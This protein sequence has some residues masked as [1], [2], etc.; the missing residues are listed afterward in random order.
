MD[1]KNV[2][3]EIAVIG[4]SIRFPG[5]NNVEKFWENIR[6]GLES[7]SRFSYDELRDSG[8]DIDLLNRP[9]YVMA[10]AII[11]NIAYIDADFFAI[12]PRESQIMDPQHRV[13]LECAW[14][15]LEGAGYT[16]PN[17]RQRVG[18]YGGVSTNSYLGN[19]YSNKR[20][21]EFVDGFQIALGNDKDFLSTRVSYKL[22]LTGPSIA[23]QTACST[24]LVA[25]HLAC[26]S[27]LNYECDMAL[28]GG[29]SIS[30]PQKSGYLYHEGGITSPD[31]HCRAF[32]AKAQGTV[33]GS[34]VGVVVLKRLKEAVADGDNIYAIVKG[35]AINNDGAMKVGYTAPSVQGQAAVIAEAL[36]VASVSPE[37]IS[38]VEAHGT[39]TPLGD[40]IE[41]AALTQAFRS[42]TERRG[43]CAIGSVKTNIGHLDAAAGIAGFI[44]TVLALHHKAL[45][46]SLHFEQ[47]N[48]QIDFG[49]SPFYV[50]TALTTWTSE[51]GPRRAGVSSF[52]IG[53]TN[54]HVILEEAP[55]LE[56]P[57]QAKQ[58]QLLLFS[59]RTG[60][61][62]EAMTANLARHF[63]EHPDL[64]LADVAYT[65]HVGRKPFT[66]RRMLVCQSLG[67]AAVALET[68]DPQ[69]I[70]TADEEPRTRAVAFMFPGQG[71]QYVQMAAD[72]YKEEPVFRQQ[73]DRCAISLL[74]PLGLDLRTVL[75]PGE[76]E[77]EQAT[78]QLSQTVLAQPALFVIEY[79]LA[80]LW[81]A[82]GVQPQAMIGH[83]IGE[84]VA[85]CLAG[86]ISLDDALAV[87]A[88]RGRLMQQLPGGAMLAVPLPENEVDSILG[89]RLSLAAVNGPSL[90]IVAGPLN[91]VEDLEQRLAQTGVS[92]Q[93]LHTSHA[94]HSAMMEP[95]MATFV[96]Q[97]EGIQLQA[98]QIPYISNVTGTWITVAE[99]TDPRYWARHLRH[100][101]RFAQGLQELLQQ[102]EQILLEV[103]PGRTLNKLAKQQLRDARA[104]IVLS[105][106]RYPHESY[107]DESFLLHTLGQLWLSGVQPDWSSFY[108]IQHRHRIPLPTYPFERKSFWVVPS[109][110]IGRDDSI[111]PAL[112]KKECSD[113]IYIHSWRRTGAPEVLPQLPLQEVE[114]SWLIFAD[115]CG[116]GAELVRQMEQKGHHVISV[117]Q[118]ERFYKIDDRQYVINPSLRNDY[119]LLFNDLYAPGRIITRIVH[120]WSVSLQRDDLPE[121]TFDQ[122]QILGYLSVISIAQAIAEIEMTTSVY[123]FVISS[124]VQE[125]TGAEY[126]SPAKA[127]V[128]GPCLVI[129]QESNYIHCRSIDIDQNSLEKSLFS[130][131]RTVIQE[132]LCDTEDMLVSFRNGHRWIHDLFK[133]PLCDKS[134]PRDLIKQDGV[135]MITGGVGDMSSVLSRNISIIQ[136]TKI[137][138]I[139]R[140]KMPERHDWDEW[141][142][143]HQE[144]D[145][146]SNKI[147]I[148]QK[149]DKSGVEYYVY[150]ADVSNESR[151]IE[152]IDCIYKR[153]GRINGLI[154]AAGIVGLG[155]IVPVKELDYDESI[156]QF[157]AKIFGT[158]VLE[159]CFSNRPL[160]FCILMSSLS[161]ILG[162]VGFTAY[163]SANIY[164]SRLAQRHNKLA[165][166][167]WTVIDWDGWRFENPWHR[168]AT[169]V[170]NA[171]TS[172]I[173]ERDACEIFQRV[174]AQPAMTHVAVSAS[175][176]QYGSNRPV[177]PRTAVVSSASQ[178]GDRQELH[179]RPNIS[180]PYVAPRNKLEQSMA[181]MWQDLL[182][183][184]KIGIEDDFFEVGG[185]SLLAIQLSTRLRSALHVELPLQSLLETP[186]I[187]KLAK[188]MRPVNP[189]QPT[190]PLAGPLV[191]I[192]PGGSEVPLFCVHPIGGSVLCYAD[193]ARELGSNQP[194]YGLQAP[195]LEAMDMYNLTL[196][197]MAA[198]YI[199]AVRAVWPTGPYHLVGLSFGG[200]VA[201]EMAQQLQRQG[202]RVGILVLLDTVT[203]AAVGRI[204]DIDDSALLAGHAREHALRFG[205]HLPVTADDLRRLPLADQLQVVL[206]H[207][208][209][210]N[211]L[212]SDT[213]TE[214]ISHFLQGYKVRIQAVQRYNP[215]IYQGNI[216]LF[217]AADIDEELFK[218]IDGAMG[219][220]LRD[221][222]YGWSMHSSEPVQ[223]H[224]VPGY[225][226][227]M[228][229]EPHVQVLARLLS[230]CLYQAQ[231]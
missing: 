136:N 158:Q 155:A 110:D 185:H 34:G 187:A 217:R 174:L 189:I 46:P 2:L 169:Y 73:V 100:T 203:P 135:Y 56:Q 74:P 153:F 197:V 45:P 214:W 159:R 229:F 10:Q 40:P 16:P 130:I 89:T 64:D 35:S 50:N 123:I 1:E 14:E 111:V 224:I 126:I 101:V 198:R 44:K 168:Q 175:E 71:T 59:A 25:V 200:I 58:S 108:T 55:P 114:S 176:L 26:Q 27:L 145:R 188:R 154:H 52:G 162:G 15:A 32:D 116:F 82:W 166:T 13:F 201:F 207:M 76:E 178:E 6:D 53:G 223:V 192:Q 28:A 173:N 221:D 148:L 113:W 218:D 54:A 79:A 163:T 96:A 42:S 24:S 183:I 90:C 227:T 95:I 57:E 70:Y 133:T 228:C 134:M 149:L 97:V 143:S 225:H 65:L 63:K 92:S 216:T 8:V 128:L 147:R 7:I 47:P 38:Y 72:L 102:E 204:L 69:R 161:T 29:A 115:D 4:I 88:M 172:T 61:A 78:Q 160:D 190:V 62:L 105:S 119:K 67:D 171:L 87:V 220:Q 122:Y 118:G 127:T 157:D 39:A 98:P 109:H 206:A 49:N 209:Q 60:S 86:V 121:T 219:E 182:G 5:A 33:S 138:L 144:N 181:T 191:A 68:G 84:Y 12:S 196:E 193:L 202:H 164:M 205:K 129:P 211:I 75:Y 132:T 170:E 85:A 80:K 230:N 151:M 77:I 91:D 120:S 51:Q 9:N 93:R 94:F 141:V 125:V 180:S 226:S 112:E 21:V 106:L 199:K 37:T 222:S 156:R 43:Y 212:P 103:G 139:G 195:G 83:S 48:P 150:E 3:E 107:D 137:V 104:P 99:A 165:A 17:I 36:G 81:M 142:A 194:L 177:Q 210:A 146:I 140:S 167:P 184:E 131:V 152:V 11:D 23:V 31:G 19:I 124:D 22:N 41:I 117:Y 179:S 18:V 231:L 208:K 215:G 186:T 20:I 213:G 30:L 66:R